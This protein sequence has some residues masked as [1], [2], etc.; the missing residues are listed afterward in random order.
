MAKRDENDRYRD[1]DLPPGPGDD[2]DDIEQPDG[3][4][5]EV[6]DLLEM[7]ADSDRPKPTLSNIVIVLERDP[8]WRG[9]V[10]SNRFAMSVEFAATPIADGMVAET[11]TLDTEVGLWLSDHYRMTVA[12]NRVSEALQVVAARHAHHPVREYLDGL[13]WDETERVAQWLVQRVGEAFLVSCVARVQRPGCKVDT[14]LI[15]VGRQGAQKSTAL[16]ILAVRPEWFADTHLDMTSKDMFEQVQGR[17]IYE[18]AELDAFRGR[19]WSRIKA[20]LSSPRDTWRRPY[21]RHSVQVDRQMVFVGT[22][23]EDSFL[24]DPTGSRRFWPVR[25]GKV[26]VRALLRD[27]DQLW[28][29]ATALYRRGARWWL[30]QDRETDL[31]EEADQYRVIDPWEDAVRKYLDEY[32]NV[33]GQLVRPAR[34]TVAEI[35]TSAVRKPLEAL[36]ITDQHRVGA[37]LRH[38]GWCKAPRTKRDSRTR[39]W[40]RPK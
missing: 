17:W 6:V 1:G 2:C 7:Y 28:A 19:E 24:G 15:L 39:A 38:L 40:E 4:V 34:V 31:A 23:N 12:T 9:R 33:E 10:R 29:E 5:A 30:E 26:D 35:L 37:I 8:R 14:T 21:A 36:T 3:P 27:R 20:V 18:L 16:R 25:C 32:V 11:D 22:T 13:V